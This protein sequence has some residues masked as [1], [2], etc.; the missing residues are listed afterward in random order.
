MTS[1]EKLDPENLP[2]AEET[3]AKL[4]FF[5]RNK[6]FIAKTFEGM[7]ISIKKEP[8]GRGYIVELEANPL[9]YFGFGPI[10]YHCDNNLKIVGTIV[11]DSKDKKRVFGNSEL[12]VDMNK[13]VHYFA[14][15][16]IAVLEKTVS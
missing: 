8:E 3:K 11:V 16:L 10:T 15:L 13:N 2:D 14:A 6:E 1:P 4:D 12:E 7:K 5:L 9:A